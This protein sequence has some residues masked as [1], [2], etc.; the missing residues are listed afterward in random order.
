MKRYLVGYDL[1]KSQRDYDAVDVQLRSIDS[2]AAR[3]LES[4]WLV[5]TELPPEDIIGRLLGADAED[6]DRFLVVSVSGPWD[7]KR[8]RSDTRLRDWFGAPSGEVGQ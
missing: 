3:V 6:N 2:S 4:T 5:E 7:G 1:K 8:V